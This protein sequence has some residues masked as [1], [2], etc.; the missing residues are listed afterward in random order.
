M[1]G[2]RHPLPEPEGRNLIDNPGLVEGC[3]RP[4]PLTVRARSS[5]HADG[6]PAIKV[7]RVKSSIRLSRRQRLRIWWA[8][9][10]LRREI[11]PDLYA[12]LA[13]EAAAAEHLSLLGQDSD[14]RA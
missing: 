5:R 11:G 9:R 12:L 6:Y 2:H 7:V 10:K 8:R 14:T 4:H 13:R 1:S 3:P